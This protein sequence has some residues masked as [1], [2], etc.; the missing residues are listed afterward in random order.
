MILVCPHTLSCLK[1]RAVV[2]G[3][4]VTRTNQVIRLLL[5]AS[6]RV[7]KWQAIDIVR[8]GEITGRP[9]GRSMS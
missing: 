1:A 6:V 5:C 3:R 7:S 4:S 9:T 2:G 8:R